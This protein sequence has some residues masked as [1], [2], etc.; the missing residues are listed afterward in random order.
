[1]IRVSDQD[2]FLLSTH[3]TDIYVKVWQEN[4]NKE[5]D[6]VNELIAKEQA[7]YFRYWVRAREDR[8]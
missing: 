4:L 1:M 8:A 6:A 2:V 3:L 5:E 7:D